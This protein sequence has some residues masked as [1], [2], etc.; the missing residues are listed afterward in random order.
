MFTLA[1][2]QK[3]SQD[4]LT[5]DIIDEFRKSPL[6]E[7]MVFDD[8]VKVQSGTSLTYSYNRVTTLPTAGG[9]AIGSK[10]SPQEAKTTTISVGLKIF[11][12]SFELDR[13][14]IDNEK[15]VVD[16]VDFQTKQKIQATVA[17]FADWFINGDSAADPLSFDG[18]DKALSGSTTEYTPPTVIDMSSAAAIKANWQDFLYYVRQTQKLMHGA[19]TI[20]PVNTDLFA[21]W[22]TVAD[23]AN[24]ATATKTEFGTEIVKYGSTII[25][26]MGDKPGTSDPIIGNVADSG[27]LI[28]DMYFARLALDGV[29]AVTPDGQKGPKVYLPDLTAPGPVK[30]GEVEMIAA[31][32][33]KA[34]RSA[35]VMRG[36]KIA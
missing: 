3:L 25:M 20:M 1:D 22:Q 4:K 31:T 10:Y 35:G 18:L 15:Q 8:T 29:H 28:T 11:G 5:H 32:A 9:R 26:D 24:S 2:A 23:Y 13:A 16:L 36:I 17:V 30:E 33:I 7:A 27:N 14:L 6:M 21:V 34:T 19:A 12:A